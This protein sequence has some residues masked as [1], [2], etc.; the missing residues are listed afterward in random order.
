MFEMAG[1]LFSTIET[2]NPFTF[3]SHERKQIFGKSGF[4]IFKALSR[5]A[6]ETL[7]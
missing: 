1:L 2:V 4:K 6:S 5:T 3:T 7:H